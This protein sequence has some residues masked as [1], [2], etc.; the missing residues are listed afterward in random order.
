MD[1]LIEKGMLKKGRR[2]FSHK[3]LDWSERR[4]H[5]VGALGSALLDGELSI[6]ISA[7]IH[8]YRFPGYKV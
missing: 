8:I 5:L 4:H 2:S 3:C 7:T 6:H 1:F